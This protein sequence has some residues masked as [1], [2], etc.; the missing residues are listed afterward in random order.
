MR[1]T[2]LL[3]GQTLIEVVVALGIAV[4]II[5]AVVSVVLSS[6]RSTEF[7]RTQNQATLLAQEGIEVVRQIR[8]TSYSTF[9]ALNGTYC[10]GKNATTL[11]PGCSLTTP[12]V[13]TYVRSVIIKQQTTPSQLGDCAQFTASVSASVKWTDGSCSNSSYC[14]GVNLVTCLENISPL[15]TP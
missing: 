11:Q 6:L 10:L 7:S 1:Y 9:Q 14:H 2:K 13:D 4:T 12:N 15:P 5:S 3:S 8:N